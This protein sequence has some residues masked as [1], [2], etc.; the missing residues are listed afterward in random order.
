MHTKLNV[1]GYIGQSF[2]VVKRVISDCYTS[3]H[4]QKT[5]INHRWRAINYIVKPAQVT[6]HYFDRGSSASKNQAKTLIYNHILKL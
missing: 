6:A 5:V 4:R 2:R 3:N 1:F